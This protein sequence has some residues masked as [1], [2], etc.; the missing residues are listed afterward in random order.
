MKIILKSILPSFLLCL[1]L[2][3]SN[4]NSNKLQA[5]TPPI[6]LEVDSF[7]ID[8][9]GTH[10][11]DVL[12]NDSVPEGIVVSTTTLTPI[13]FPFGTLINPPATGFV[14]TVDTL[15]EGIYSFEYQVTD[16][17]GISFNS[18][19]YIIIGGNSSSVDCTNDCVWPG[20]VNGDGLVN[21]F[22][23][24]PLG[25]AFN[26]QG[27]PRLDASIDFTPQEATDWDT[28]FVDGRNYKHADTDGNA[29]IDAN[30]LLAIEQNYASEVS[31]KTGQNNSTD[32]D[33][34]LILD[35]QN[36]IITADAPV[37]ANILL[38]DADA[39]AEDVYGLAFN[40]LY[41]SGI[42]DSST[43]SINFDGTWLGNSTNTI[44]LTKNL[45]DGAIDAAITRTN[46]VNE[47]GYGVLAQLSFWVMEDVIIGSGKN[48][49][50]EELVLSLDFGQ[51]RI[52]NTNQEEIEVNTV[53]DQIV[54][55]EVPIIASPNT[56]IRIYP[57][58]A[59]HQLTIDLSKATKLQAQQ[60][61]IL[62]IT[63][64]TVYE[65]KVVGQQSSIQVPVADLESAYY[66][67]LVHTSEGI[68]SEKVLIFDF[69]Y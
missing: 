53:G 19:A 5:Q 17:A 3:L 45:F 1:L 50:L 9:I 67:L 20:E 27:E 58:P 62:S 44:S 60:I 29:F 43:V 61:Q 24:L 42:V 37:I 51:V 38:G 14:L 55:N 33:F 40:I 4:S 2:I 69:S 11:L 28:S 41:P 52:L 7:Y 59:S 34:A 47:S 18:N 8:T 66:F 16:S 13:T 32:A 23:V 22:D 46:M 25:V 26:T 65:Q 63:G 15:L 35:I 68:V 6:V 31:G 30:D 36:D 64:Q 49:D 10:I 39:L 12:A 54:I 56:N 48:N 57:N 21:V